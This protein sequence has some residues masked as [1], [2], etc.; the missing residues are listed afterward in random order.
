MENRNHS[1]VTEFFLLGL[2]ADPNLQLPLF[3]FFL[4]VYIFTVTGNLLLIVA[5]RGDHRLH[6]PMY[7]FLANLSFLD[8]GHTS[9]TVPKMLVDFLMQKKRISFD[10][11]LIQVYSFLLLGDT[12]CVL[13][14]FM[15]YDRFVAICNPL[16]YRTIMKTAACIQMISTS[17]LI[18]CIIS[19]VDIFILY[20]LSFCGPNTI[21]H[22]FC[23]APSLLQLSCS[24][25]ALANVVKLVG[26]CILLL[27]PLSFILYSYIH[28]IRAVLRIRSRRHKAFSTCVSHLTIVVL[29]YGSALFMYMKPEHTGS[30]ADKMLSVFYTIITP[31]LN[32]I[33]YSLRNKDVQGSLKKGVSKEKTYLNCVYLRHRCHCSQSLAEIERIG[34]RRTEMERREEE[35]AVSNRNRRRKKKASKEERSGRMEAESPGQG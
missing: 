29:F 27:L 8:I 19:S 4:I 18:G 2:S 35:D 17:W 14:A 24:D 16:H 32:P 6:H 22:F 13:L 1:K 20:Q 3:Q 34:R 10:G 31:M 25:M 23:E 11:C 26:G 12:E 33:I 30:L 9:I 28:I 7:L 15:A 5:V 21:N